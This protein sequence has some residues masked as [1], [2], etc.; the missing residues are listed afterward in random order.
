MN[1]RSDCLERHSIYDRAMVAEQPVLRVEFFGIPRAR[2]GVA[3]TVVPLASGDI[4]LGD[5]VAE[6]ARRFPSLASDCFH[7]GALRDGFAA[8]VDGRRFVCR[9]EERIQA[10][11]TVLFFSA[12]A[13]G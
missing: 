6:L 4:R 9:S 11:E 10:G 2:A 3:E 8:N 12:D 13:G 7:N 1:G 5:L